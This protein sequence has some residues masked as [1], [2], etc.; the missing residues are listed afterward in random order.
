[1]KKIIACYSLFLFA[2]LQIN[3]SAQGPLRFKDEVANLTANDGSLKNENIILFTGSSSI[4]KWNSLQN[5]FPK[6]NI[7]NSGFGGSQTADLLYY[8]DKLIFPDTAKM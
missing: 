2:F 6:H 5:D 4:K 3:V 8:V 1:M 7:V